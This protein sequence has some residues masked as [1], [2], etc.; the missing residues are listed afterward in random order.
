MKRYKGGLYSFKK[1]TFAPKDCMLVKS[2]YWCNVQMWTHI[3]FK[4]YTP[5]KWHLSY[6][7]LTMCECELHNYRFS[8]TFCTPNSSFAFPFATKSH[9]KPLDGSVYLVPKSSETVPLRINTKPQFSVLDPLHSKENVNRMQA[10][11]C[12]VIQYAAHSKTL[13]NSPTNWHLFMN[14]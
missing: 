9:W 4:W 6:L 2:M 8:Q 13:I 11:S 3:F 12:F 1:Y 10:R 5:S 7:S 14:S